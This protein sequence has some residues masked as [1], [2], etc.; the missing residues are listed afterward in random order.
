[1][2][3]I[4]IATAV[5]AVATAGLAAVPAPAQAGAA[6]RVTATTT[7]SQVKV[8]DKVV[9]TGKV[10]P[11]R[12]AAGHKVTLEEKF[13]PGKPWV[14]QRKATVRDN[15]T[16]RIAD[17]PAAN[18][19][20]SYRVV[21]PASGQHAKGVSGN[22]LVK[23]YQWTL[24][25][26]HTFVN[27]DGMLQTSTLHL[28]G[29]VYPRSLVAEFTGLSTVEVNVDH[30]CIAFRGTF[31]VAD[32]SMTGAQS[33]LTAEADGVQIYASTLALGQADVQRIAL[34]SP[35]KLRFSAQSVVP[36]IDG[37]GGIGSPGVLC[38]Q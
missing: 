16:Y 18:T 29:T 25:D 36:G 5:L 8:G 37:F 1:M 34:D 3:T 12:A 28:N 24:L 31:G 6:W 33:T 7:S 35:L 20:H 21:M 17:R 22:M 15:G 30:R 23:V 13:K 11:V 38:V 26:T 4:A 14:V 19:V 10:S 32:S 2:R 9:F 27:Q